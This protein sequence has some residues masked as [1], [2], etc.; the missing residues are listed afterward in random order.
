MQK[1][2]KFQIDIDEPYALQDELRYPG[3]V[4]LEIFAHWCD[5]C[6]SIDPIF[7]NH[8][9]DLSTRKLKF[10]RIQHAYVPWLRR[11]HG[12]CRPTFLFFV[13]GKLEKV[14]DGIDTPMLD[15]LIPQLA[16]EDEVP[17][18]TFKPEE[19]F[20]ELDS[21]DVY[22][23]YYDQYVATVKAAE[24]ERAIA[25]DTGVD[26]EADP[27]RE[28]NALVKKFEEQFRLP[29][30]VPAGSVT[31]VERPARTEASTP[32]TV[33]VTETAE[34]PAV[35]GSEAA[36]EGGDPGAATDTAGKTKNIEGSEGAE[37]GKEIEEG[38]AM[39]RES[40]RRL[41]TPTDRDT[42]DDQQEQVNMDSDGNG[43]PVK[44]GDEAPEEQE[45]DGA[46]NY[47]E[48]VAEE[49]REEVVQEVVETVVQEQREEQPA[50]EAP[51]AGAQ[52]QPDKTNE[53]PE[54]VEAPED[55]QQGPTQ[56]STPDSAR[57]EGDHEAP[58]DI[59]TAG[60]NG[61]VDVLDYDHTGE[62]VDGEVVNIVEQEEAQVRT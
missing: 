58:R 23:D 45:E 56:T 33:T 48:N 31:P 24:Q 29:M 2:K 13:G 61:T 54:E 39:S 22:Q 7:R 37:E 32:E 38:D 52:P 27:R 15:T 59:K 12:H 19:F 60:T 21:D 6:K 46:F 57:T 47:E 42:E 30:S 8:F 44:P 3:L 14:V 20:S 49:V 36:V 25:M 28:Y 50:E 55:N 34:A 11:Y 18:V 41:R 5:V 43:E 62:H 1:Q 40:E 51:T 35:Q 16:P 4:V 9:V 17:I 10:V 26:T 53:E